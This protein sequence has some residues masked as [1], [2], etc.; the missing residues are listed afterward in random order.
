M[1][2]NLTLTNIFDDFEVSPPAKPGIEP[3]LKNI[4]DTIYEDSNEYGPWIAGG[5]GRQLAVSPECQEFADI[6]VW[7]SGPTSYELCM[8]RLN[9]TFG[10]Y[11]YET[12]TS[13]NARTYTIGDHKV[14]L[15]RR[16]YYDSLDD[17]FDNFDFTCCQ[18][19]VDKDFKLSGPGLD[20]ARN[21][22]LKLNKLDIRGF[23]ARYA[24]Y[25]GY[26]YTMPNEEFLDIIN[27]EEINYEFDATTLGY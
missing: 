8:I 13:D 1:F 27:N 17:V 12:F 4:V 14:Q 15:I 10:N 16:A 11:M 2:K 6:D 18:V 9:N 25:V 22:V 23:L 21:Y 20:D 24:K 3:T 26:G 5:M 19:A 7:F